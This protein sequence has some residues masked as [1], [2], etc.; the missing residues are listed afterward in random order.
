M[1]CLEEESILNLKK[2]REMKNIYKHTHIHTTKLNDP[3]I[4][5]AMGRGA[6]VTLMREVTRPTLRMEGNHCL[7]KQGI[8]VQPPESAEK[9]SYQGKG[10]GAG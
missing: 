6:P 1:F 2:K 8:N 4:E 7:P 10:I 5:M 9:T 3:A